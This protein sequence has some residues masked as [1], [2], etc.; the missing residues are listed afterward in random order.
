MGRWTPVGVVLATVGCV[1]VIPVSPAMRQELD[2]P[3]AVGAREFRILGQFELQIASRPTIVVPTKSAA[4]AVSTPDDSTFLVTVLGI[5]LAGSPD[6]LH[7]TFMESSAAGGSYTLRAVNATPLGAAIPV[8][9][10][11]YQ[12]VPCTL[13]VRLRC[14][15]PLHAGTLEDQGVRLGVMK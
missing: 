15:E 8:G 4:L 6:T 10:L 13:N 7:L 14:D 9:M 2:T 12:Y 11:T 3:A 1:S 5:P